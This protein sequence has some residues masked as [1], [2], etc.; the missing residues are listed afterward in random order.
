MSDLERV[1]AACLRI[2]EDEKPGV[3]DGFGYVDHCL[4]AIARLVLPCC[5]SPL[6]S[7]QAVKVTAT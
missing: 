4:P 5:L 7:M 3:V 6:P 2:I 1:R